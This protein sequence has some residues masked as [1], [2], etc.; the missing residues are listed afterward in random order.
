M[1][2]SVGFEPTNTAS[3]EGRLEVTFTSG[4]TYAYDGVPADE[5]A[6]LINAPSAGKYFLANIKDAYREG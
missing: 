1:I 3:S 5:Y 4:R 2:L 6:S